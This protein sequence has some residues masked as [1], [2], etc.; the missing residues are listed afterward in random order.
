PDLRS[1]P[2]RRSSDLLEVCRS[3][4]IDPNEVSESQI[5]LQLSDFPEVHWAAVAWPAGDADRDLADSA[6][7][8]SLEARVRR[9]TSG[10]D[11]AGSDRKST[12][13]NSSHVK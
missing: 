10:L 11:G 13:L 7:V 8:R 4:G 12:R 1:F 3:A 5:E 6:E 2:T 9:M